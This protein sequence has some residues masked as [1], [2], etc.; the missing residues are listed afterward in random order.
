M[1]ECAAGMVARRGEKAT[2]FRGFLG[3]V[4]FDEISWGVGLVKPKR[5]GVVLV[6]VA[7]VLKRGCRE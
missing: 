1:A 6:E 4:I 2:D 3:N 7:V 5:H